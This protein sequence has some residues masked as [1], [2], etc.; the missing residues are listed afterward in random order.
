MALSMSDETWGVLLQLIKIVQGEYLKKFDGGG[1][2]AYFFGS[3][4]FEFLTS[5]VWKR[6][7]YFLGSENFSFGFLD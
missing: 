4:I 3:E 7:S 5:G 2:S 1:G 6:L